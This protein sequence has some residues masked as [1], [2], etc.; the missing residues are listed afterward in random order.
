[1]FEFYSIPK[2]LKIFEIYFLSKTLNIFEFSFL[3]KILN[4][5]F[6]QNEAAHVQKRL[7]RVAA[8]HYGDV[9]SVSPRALQCAVSSKRVALWRCVH[10]AK[11]SVLLRLFICTTSRA[12]MPITLAVTC[13]LSESEHCSAQCAA[14]E[15]LCSYV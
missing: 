13:I 3:S 2:T 7:F 1:M 5:I 10:K 6:S 12:A 8:R 4:S 15:W 14:G 9:Q 11:T